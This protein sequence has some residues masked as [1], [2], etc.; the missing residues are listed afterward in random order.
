MNWIRTSRRAG[1]TYREV[2]A[3][4][5]GKVEPNL[6]SL[7]KAIAPRVEG[8]E[9]MPK[10]KSFAPPDQRGIHE[11]IDEVESAVDLVMELIKNIKRRLNEFDRLQAS[12]YNGQKP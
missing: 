1:Q 12:F 11:L 8:L 10:G 2:N 4:T 6:D 3:M 9:R 7:E 5:N